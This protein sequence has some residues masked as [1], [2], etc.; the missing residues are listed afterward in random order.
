[1]SRILVVEDREDVGQPLTRLLERH[2]HEVHLHESASVAWKA[3]QRDSL[4]TH[5]LSDNDCPGMDD[6]MAFLT[7]VIGLEHGLQHTPKLALMTGRLGEWYGKEL[8]IHTC[9]RLSIQFFPKPMDF[10]EL[11]EWAK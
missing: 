5:I 6:G 9:R 8:L 2:G 10:D 1:M 7:R 3:F 11:A 4:F